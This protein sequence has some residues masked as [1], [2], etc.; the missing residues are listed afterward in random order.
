VE[1]DSGCPLSGTPE[2]HSDAA[3][4][5]SDAVN[6][7]VSAL[8]WGATKKWVAVRLSDG[9]S[10]GVLYDH[11]RDAI[12]H[13]LHERQ[14]AYICI[15]PGGMNACQAESFMRMTRNAYDAGAHLTDPEAPEIIRRLTRRDQAAQMRRI[16]ISR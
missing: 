12:A 10:D 8:G 1:H 11:R 16:K 4:R 14:C 9:G 3:R 7:H 2:L 6:L 15:S 5:C 13:Q